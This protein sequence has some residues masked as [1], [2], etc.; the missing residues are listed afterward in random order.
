MS[1]VARFS[2]AKV[3]D[4]VCALLLAITSCQPVTVGRALAVDVRSSLARP[5]EQRRRTLAVAVAR[6]WPSRRNR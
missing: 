4:L 3:F 1:Q 6:P 5:L 2:A